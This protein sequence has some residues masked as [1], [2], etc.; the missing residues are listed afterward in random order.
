MKYNLTIILTVLQQRCWRWCRTDVDISKW[1]CVSLINK[2]IIR[3]FQTYLMAGHSFGAGL[4]RASFWLCFWLSGA[5]DHFSALVMN[6]SVADYCCS[7]FVFDKIEWR[8]TSQIA[9]PS[10]AWCEDNPSVC[11]ELNGEL[12]NCPQQDSN[13][14]SP[15]TSLTKG[16]TLWAVSW[17]ITENERLNFSNE[18]TC[19][20]TVPYNLAVLRVIVTGIGW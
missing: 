3:R 18:G 5:K 16:R 10:P 12:Q 20:D 17:S 8:H 2:S 9:K 15:L 4:L 11:E 7:I 6:L 1:L 19:W 13:D 14:K